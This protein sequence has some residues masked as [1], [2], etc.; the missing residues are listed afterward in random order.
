MSFYREKP[1]QSRKSAPS[2]VL[3]KILLTILLLTG[4][5]S[6]FFLL[7]FRGYVVDTAA[8]P[9]L[10]L[11]FLAA[12]GAEPPVREALSPTP[13]VTVM[14]DADASSTLLTPL[15]AVGIDITAV[16]EGS[17]EEQMRQAGCNAVVVDMRDDDGALSYISKLPEAIEAAAS[18]ATPGRNEAIRRMNANP[19]IYSIARISCFSDEKVG[20]LLPAWT[21]LRAGGVSWRDAAARPWLAPDNEA[22]QTY[23]LAICREVAALGFDE[24]L[25]RTCAYPDSPTG[26][27]QGDD[28]QVKQ[29]RADTLDAFYGAVQRVLAEEGVNLSLSWEASAPERTVGTQYNGQ[30]PEQLLLCADRIWTADDPTRAQ[31]VF[32][33]GGLSSADLPLVLIQAQKGTPSGSWAILSP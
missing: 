3:G 6:A 11:P 22:V 29:T 20:A 14:D 18:D 5:A 26:S 9:R 21:I 13:G 1:Q 24:I 27:F 16:D 7:F 23:L 28:T 30:S 15:H 8:G 32:A 17:V 25:L 12:Q 33:T 4:V 2:Q 19:N 10:Q 31:E